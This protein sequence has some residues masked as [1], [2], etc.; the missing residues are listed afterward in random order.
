MI[1]RIFILL[2]LLLYHADTE[3]QR[4]PSLPE[5]F[6]AIRHPFII[7][8]AIRITRKALVLTDSIKHTGLTDTFS[9]G[10]QLDAFRHSIWM[11]LLSQKIRHKKVIALGKAHEKG[12]YRDFKKG[13]AEEG[14]T[15]DMASM[16]MD[17]HNNQKGADHGRCNK[18]LAEKDLCELI[19]SRIKSGE[20]VI[21]ARN[22]QGE[23]LTCDNRILK[24][25]EYEQKWVNEKCLVPSDFIYR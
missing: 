20:M 22:H 14:L 19:I 10:G 5:K 18:S 3:A 21:I 25:E 4:K 13:R 17:L 2:A 9:N 24:K 11:A 15:P 16:M 12:N 23:F 7:K 8:K 6:W 1:F